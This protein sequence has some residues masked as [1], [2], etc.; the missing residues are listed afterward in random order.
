MIARLLLILS[1]AMDYGIRGKTA[2]V[3]GGS[4][5]I[6]KGIAGVLAGEGARVAVCARSRELLQESAREIAEK[7][8]SETLAVAA[9]VEKSD[10][11]ARVVKTVMD[12]FGGVDIVVNG[13]ANFN[14]G[15]L[16]EVAD[17]NYLHHFNV[18]F[19]GYVRFA[20]EVV[21]YMKEQHWGRIIN[22]AGGAARIARPGSFSAGAIN[23][24]VLNFTKH[25]AQEVAPFGITVNSIH[26]GGARTR[27]RE[28]AFDREIRT[29]GITRAQAEREH[30][31][32]IPIGRYIEPE[33]AGHAAAFFCSVQASAV[34]GQVLSM[35]GGSMQNVLI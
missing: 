17:E 19:L 22:L 32:R 4:E 11:V 30:V 10:D 9:D 1:A 18:K 29:R 25:L 16:F 26:P 14:D 21:P 8:G 35:D 7:T 23:M 12:R 31:A 6:G 15:S 28:I 13:A 27:R 2:I 5:G 24:A 20:R 3:T 33:D 34:T